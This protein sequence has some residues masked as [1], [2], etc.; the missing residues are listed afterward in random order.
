MLL[1]V[2]QPVYI[3]QQLRSELRFGRSTKSSTVV[4]VLRC[5]FLHFFFLVDSIFLYLF[6]FLEIIVVLRLLQTINI[7]S[8]I[9]TSQ[10]NACDVNV[11]VFF[12]VF[13]FTFF[14]SCVCYSYIFSSRMSNRMNKCA[15]ELAAVSLSMEM[16]TGCM[17]IENF[18]FFFRIYLFNFWPIISLRSFSPLRTPTDLNMILYKPT[19]AYNK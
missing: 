12:F 16:F 2:C 13:S 10:L 17:C 3:T 4:V 1:T 5:S 15:I 8:S 14:I 6:A 19:I 7:S 11:F 9:K 18:I